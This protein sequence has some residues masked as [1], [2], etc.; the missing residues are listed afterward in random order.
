MPPPWNVTGR[1]EGIKVANSSVR[2][3]KM[4]PADRAKQFMPFAALKGYEE[5]LRRKEKI[6]VE[7]VELSEEMKEELDRQFKQVSHNDIITV[8]YYAEEE[9]LKITGMVAKI[10]VDA[11]YLKVVNTKIPFGDIYSIGKE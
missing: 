4:S 1:L 11:R 5:A 10:D 8:V 9:Y 6:V 3:T 2:R 7:K